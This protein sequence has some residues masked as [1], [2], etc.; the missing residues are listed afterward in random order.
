MNWKNWIIAYGLDKKLHS[1]LFAVGKCIHK[2][3]KLNRATVST[4]I[5]FEFYYLVPVLNWA[6]EI[7]PWGFLFQFNIGLFGFKAEAKWV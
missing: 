4:G 2:D 6:I 1:Y 5:R 7:K 3:K